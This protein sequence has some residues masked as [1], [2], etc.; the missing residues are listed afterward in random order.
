MSKTSYIQIRT[1]DGNVLYTDWQNE[2]SWAKQHPEP[3]KERRLKDFSNHLSV[4]NTFMA[5]KSFIREAPVF[6]CAVN[7]KNIT[8]LS[9]ISEKWED[10]LDEGQIAFYL[11]EDEIR[12]LINAAISTTGYGTDYEPPALTTARLS[13]EESLDE[14]ER[15]H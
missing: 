11:Y 4:G 13:L 15:L 12:A 5:R 1:T 9:V 6:E 7:P 10:V 8:S 14:Q 2:S 3:A